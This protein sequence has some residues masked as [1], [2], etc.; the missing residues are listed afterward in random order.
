MCKSIQTSS[1]PK[2]VLNK[3]KCLLLHVKKPIKDKSKNIKMDLR[4]L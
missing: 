4:G 2:E 1:I 3:M